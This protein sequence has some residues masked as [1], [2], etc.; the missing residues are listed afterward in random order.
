MASEAGRVYMAL[1]GEVGSE[2]TKKYWE[3]LRDE[4][5]KL[6]SKTPKQ[7]AK[8]LAKVIRERESGSSHNR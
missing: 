5:F 1:E 6:A 3:S 2:L 4:Y 8:G 7:I